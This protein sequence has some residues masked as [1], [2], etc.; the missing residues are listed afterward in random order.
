MSERASERRQQAERPSESREY[1]GPPRRPIFRLPTIRLFPS[2]STS[3]GLAVSQPVC[4]SVPSPSVPSHQTLWSAPMLLSTTHN[5]EEEGM[6]LLSTFNNSSA[7]P[8][9]DA[10]DFVLYPCSPVSP[11]RN[12]E[13][14][15]GK[16]RYLQMCCFF[17]NQ[18]SILCFHR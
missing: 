4:R 6:K 12:R 17:R 18:D 14:Q 9:S 11:C 13:R 2:A 15:K 5:V 1:V 10:S 8:S 7:S 3:I 16:E